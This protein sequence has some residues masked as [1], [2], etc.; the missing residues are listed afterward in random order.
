MHYP[1]LSSS[2]KCLCAGHNN[3]NSCILN[4]KSNESILLKIC[5]FPHIFFSSV[6]NLNLLLEICNLYFLFL[7]QLNSI[8]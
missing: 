2:F 5:F 8:P 4:Y 1:T 3:C 6:V 7:S